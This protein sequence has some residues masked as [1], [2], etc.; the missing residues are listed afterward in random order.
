MKDMNSIY[1]FEL[2]RVQLTV[3]PDSLCAKFGKITELEDLKM[4]VNT[5]IELCGAF[6][7][8]M[9]MSVLTKKKG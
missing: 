1:T 9:N 4:V 5:R 3:L 7:N 2:K 8:S 6:I